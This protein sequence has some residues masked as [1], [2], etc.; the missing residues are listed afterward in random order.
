MSLFDSLQMVYSS[1]GW[2]VRVPEAQGG[3]LAGSSWNSKTNTRNSLHRTDHRRLP[4]LQRSYSVRLQRK[5][6]LLKHEAVSDVHWRPGE[7]YIHSHELRAEGLKIHQ[8]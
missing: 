7:K 8:A 5:G 6:A 2:Q 4:H 3:L 1:F